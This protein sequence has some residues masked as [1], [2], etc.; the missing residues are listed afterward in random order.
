MV[1]HHQVALAGCERYHLELRASAQAPSGKSSVKF[2]LTTRKLSKKQKATTV[3]I[4][5]KLEEKTVK[6]NLRVKK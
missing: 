2:Q 6:A 4:T 5:A 1:P 3:R